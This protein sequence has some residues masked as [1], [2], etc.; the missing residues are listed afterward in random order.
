M[1]SESLSLRLIDPS[2]GREG[3]RSLSIPSSL[4]QFSLESCVVTSTPQEGETEREGDMSLASGTSVGYGAAE[5]EKGTAAGKDEGDNAV[6]EVSVVEQGCDSD[7]TTIGDSDAEC[8]DQ[9]RDVLMEDTAKEREEDKHTSDTSSWRLLCSPNTNSCSDTKSSA[10]STN[11][12][13]TLVVETHYSQL[14]YSQPDSELALVIDLPE[15]QSSQ[16]TAATAEPTVR[17]SGE[18]NEVSAVVNGESCASGEVGKRGL[19]RE[20]WDLLQREKESE[21]SRR[22]LLSP[23]KSQQA[24]ECEDVELVTVGGEG[25]SDNDELVDE[26]SSQGFSLRLSQSQTRLSQATPTTNKATP[27]A[28]DAAESDRGAPCEIEPNCALHQHSAVE[29]SEVVPMTVGA[30]GGVCGDL[31]S[32]E[33]PKPLYESVALTDSVAFLSTPLPSQPSQHSHITPSHTPPSHSMS[34]QPQNSA[35]SSQ[36]PASCSQTRVNEI[37]QASSSSTSTPFQFQIPQTGLLKPHQYSSPP[38]LHTP[39]PPPL[40]PSPS[41]P[42]TITQTHSLPKP[43]EGEVHQDFH[44]SSEKNIP[45]KTRIKI[46]KDKSKDKPVVSEATLPSQAIGSVRKKKAVVPEKFYGHTEPGAPVCTSSGSPPSDGENLMR[47]GVRESAPAGGGGGGGGFVLGAMAVSRDEETSRDDDSQNEI[48]ISIAGDSQFETS[49]D[50][51]RLLDCP[52]NPPPSSANRRTSSALCEPAPPALPTQGSKISSSTT[53][54]SNIAPQG[55]AASIFSNIL[56]S[57]R[58]AGS[59]VLRE[60]RGDPFEFDSQGCDR[61]A[62]FVLQRKKKKTQVVEGDGEREERCEGDVSHMESDMSTVHDKDGPQTMPTSTISPGS[63]STPVITSSLSPSSQP[64]SSTPSRPLPVTQQCSTIVSLFPHPPQTPQSHTL[65]T[66]MTPTITTPGTLPLFSP[67]H[68]PFT[69]PTSRVSQDDIR[70]ASAQFRDS[71]SRYVLRHT[72]TYRHVVEVKVVSQ[73]V[74]E[75]DRIVDGLST[76]WQ[77]GWR[78]VCVCVCVCECVCVCVCVCVCCQ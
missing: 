7:A 77:V 62:E 54:Q 64:H 25:R 55:T 16:T 59:R 27:T 65:P 13:Q 9:R 18:K 24:V 72:H 56:T 78:C 15:S 67:H 57:R 42:P 14:T 34:S 28:G 37:S 76:V 36:Q 63:S 71:L 2:P 26:G 31:L 45:S 43:R 6:M 48:E 75:G 30:N 70:R 20:A 44:S 19:I 74:Y 46:N 38:I 3:D 35:T 5:D 73:E 21:R 69:S 68:L 12:L 61:P 10:G 22:G 39:T 40:T 66:H 23:L 52:L 60:D 4:P 50:S 29:D 51:Q 58:R 49:A 11:H 17:E 32:G 33:L 8:D 53:P 1:K 41:P 47:D